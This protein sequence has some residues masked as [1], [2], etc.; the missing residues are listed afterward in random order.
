[1][2]FQD[3]THCKISIVDIRIFEYI[4]GLRILELV[5]IR[6][7]NYPSIRI[8]SILINMLIVQLKKIIIVE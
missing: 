7:L 1:M 8:I 3:F 4:F 5:L 6:I 2:R